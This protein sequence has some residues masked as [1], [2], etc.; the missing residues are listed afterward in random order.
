MA[1]FQMKFINHNLRI[2]VK[3]ALTNNL[4]VETAFTPLSY[5]V[6]IICERHHYLQCSKTSSARLNDAFT[7]A[8]R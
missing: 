6:H 5:Y 2:N 4:R 3:E 7:S 8:V 1:G